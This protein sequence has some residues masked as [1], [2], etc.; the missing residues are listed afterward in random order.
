MI[1]CNTASYSQTSNK[2]L[3]NFNGHRS[4][5]ERP[6]KKIFKHNFWFPSFEYLRK[7][8]KRILSFEL[9]KFTKNTAASNVY[10]PVEDRE[11][12]DNYYQALIRFQYQRLGNPILQ[13]KIVSVYPYYGGA[14][15]PHWTMM[16][17][18]SLKSTFNSS[19]TTS[20]GATAHAS[21]GTYF[22]FKKLFINVNTLWGITQFQAVNE[23]T[24]N[25][26]IPI[27]ARSSKYSILKFIPKDNL[28][29]IGIGI[30]I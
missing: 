7:K 19:S 8:N 6:N 23:I 25:P 27:D 22:Q 13:D 12:I 20:L 29:R 5:F 1:I 16:D 26:D 15:T 18:A 14:I 21:L 24:D 3:L 10:I 28:F 17:R 11:Y 9:A 2:L 4:D 30:G